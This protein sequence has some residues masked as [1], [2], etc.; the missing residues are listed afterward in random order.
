V[1]FERSTVAAAGGLALAAA[2]ALQG[3]AP[4]GGH[5]Q[6]RG[7]PE[8]GVVTIE[9]QPVTLQ[10]ELPGRTTPYEVSD[11]RPQVGGILK[12]RDF[13]EGSNVKAGQRLYQIDPAPYRAA[14]DQAAAQLASAEAT[15]MT[16]QAKAERYADLVKIKGVSQ[17]DFDDAEAAYR[18]A[19]AAVR[20]QKAALE[21]ARINLDY[22]KV[23]APISGR[24]GAS[25]F[26]QGALVT[27]GQATALSTIQ[28]LDPIYVDITQSAAELLKLRRDIAAGQLNHGG[29][30]SAVVRLKLE[31]G[32]DYPLPGKLEFTDITVDQ[33]T[34]SVTLRAVFPNPDGV[35]LPGL[36]VRAIVTEG[37]DNQGLLAPQQGVTRDQ[38]GQPVAWIVDAAGKA[39]LRNLRTPRAI[40]DKWLVSDGLKPGDRVVVE[41]VQRLQPGVQ[42]HAVPAQPP[43]GPASD[44][45]R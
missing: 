15:L 18:A 9:P 28:R 7:P 16:D 22:T 29:P 14:Y 3:C 20:Q 37:I 34:G 12:S 26:T 41:G 11:V 17:Q 30:Q 35:L 6:N 2:L 44:A 27:A 43:P 21:A 31:D 40:G 1:F 45:G 32:S 4:G 33:T 42:V 19:A 23:T 5:G 36:F 25:A 38:T 13:V 24:I 8:V 10:I 39:Q